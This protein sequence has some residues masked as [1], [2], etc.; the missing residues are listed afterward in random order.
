MQHETLQALG[1]PVEEARKAFLRLIEPVRPDLWRYCLRLTGSAWDAE[2]LVQ[3][4]L[5][6]AYARLTWWEPVD[7]RPYLFRIASNAWIDG[8]RKRRAETVELD[9]ARATAADTADP[10]ETWAAMEHLV[11]ALPPRQRVVFLLTQVFDFTAGEA[12]AMLGMTEGGVKAALHR[13]RAG[14]KEAAPQQGAGASQTGPEASQTVP[15]ARQTVPQPR[16][17]APPPNAVVAAYLDAFNRRDP[18]A[19][20]ALLTDGATCDIVECGV[21]YGKAVIRK[22]SLTDW[23]KEPNVQWAEYG[24]L[25]GAPVVFVYFRTEQHEKA[26]G[27]LITLETADGQILGIG[28]YFFT[29]E[30]I[31]YAA[32]Q[33]GVPDCAWGYFYQG[34]F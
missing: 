34:G 30:I 25:D 24:E 4:T 31:R 18:D 33:L 16:P 19:I 6:K 2:D 27:Q 8:L 12:A 21:E 3:E 26:L 1:R 15:D 14:L 10:A 7:A 5:M 29:P 17:S 23:A 22:Y 9:E 20:A 28:T 32:A 11:A 13:A